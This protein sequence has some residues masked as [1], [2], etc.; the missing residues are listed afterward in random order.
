M[1]KKGDTVVA[2]VS[3]GVDSMVMLFALGA[4]K[5]R[6][7]ISIIVAH[8]NHNLRGK[9]SAGDLDFVKKAAGRMGLPFAGATLAKGELEKKGVSM[10]EAAR[11]RRYGFLERVSARRKASKIALGHTLDDQ[12]ETILMRLIKGSSLSGLA[13]IPATRGSI[14]R[15]LIE[16]KR[17]DIERFA[18]EAGI[19]WRAD[20]TNLKAD[21]LRNDIR[22]NLIP[23]IEKRFNPN[24]KASL[25]RTAGLLRRDE[26]YIDSAVIKACSRA[27]IER[28]QGRVVMELERLKKLHPALS[29]RVFL[30]AIDFLNMA[31]EVYSQHV[32]IFFESMSLRAKPNAVFTLP[33]QLF[34]RREY[35]RIIVSTL[36]LEA[37]RPFDAAL[38]VPGIT[39]IKEAG[40]VIKASLLKRDKAPCVFTR[41]LA[42]RPRREAGA[43]RARGLC[44]YFDYDEIDLPLRARSMRPGDRITP[45]GMKGRKKIKEVFIERKIPALERR[46]TPIISSGEIIL[47]AIGA[48]EADE[49]KVRKTTARVLKL[50]YRRH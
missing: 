49:G 39:R 45:L 12:A 48:A 25:A 20:A 43:R 26:E 11:E 13:G 18:E 19:G 1:L 7:G 42:T 14:I 36:P 38:K 16:V 10:Q 23:F 46:K 27:V 9:A 17:E 33:G 2:A 22:L 15:P 41:G 8:L 31:S 21:Y 3:G 28:G 4:M 6:L 34:I 44:A 35:G 5:E 32:N 24:I 50:E 37:V 47:W 40:C 29:S 30:T